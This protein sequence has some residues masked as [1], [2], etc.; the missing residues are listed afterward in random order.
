MMASIK[1]KA[2]VILPMVRAFF[3]KEWTRFVRTVSG[4][5]GS[6]ER[7]FG[8]VRSRRALFRS[9]QKRLRGTTQSGQGD[10]PLDVKRRAF[11]KYA[12]FGGAVFLAGKY[13]GPLMNTMRGDTVLS[14]KTFDNFKMVETGKQLQISDDDGNEILTIDK[15]SF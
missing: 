11:L 1:H 2:R 15:E 8:S 4:R 5:A 12:V 10:L 9:I 13:F 6:G 3:E 7:L 14:E